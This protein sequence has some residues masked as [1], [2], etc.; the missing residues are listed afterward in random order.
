MND[1]QL[2]LGGAF[3][4]MRPE[5]PQR[6]T[7]PRIAVCDL[8][9]GTTVQ[10]VYLLASRETRTTKAG[11]PFYKL[12]LSDR[13]GTIDCTVWEAGEF[14]G[15]VSAG[16]LVWVEARVSEYLGKPQL[17]AT[18][19]GAAPRVR[20]RAGIFCRQPIGIST[21]SRVSWS[22]T[23]ARCTTPITADCSSGSSMIP[24]LWRPS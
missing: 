12:K 3:D 1:E 2:G 4:N 16:D 19:V 20:L 6:H 15:G 9:P 21:S 24:N 10:G 17:E 8:T 13:T 11:K 7:P 5:Q 23:S 18:N 22:S 14:E